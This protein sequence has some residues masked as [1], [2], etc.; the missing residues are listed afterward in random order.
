VSRRDERGTAIV[1]LALTLPI[2]LLLTLGAIDFGRAVYVQTILGNAARDAARFASVDPRN[3]SC[4][5]SVAGYNSSIAN[6][7][8]SDVT[9]ALPGSIDLDQ[10]VT[11]TTKTSYQP[12]SALVTQAIGVNSIALSASATMRIRNV[13]SSPLACPPPP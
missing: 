11:V 1:E 2:F 3:A 8:A 12:I 4:I 13:A 5:K 7:A 10:P 9:I 6:L